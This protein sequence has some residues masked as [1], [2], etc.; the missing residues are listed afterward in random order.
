[1]FV[2]AVKLDEAGRQILERAGRRELA[3]DKRAAPALSGDFATDDEF[4]ARVLEDRF[5]DAAS[6]PVRTRS[7]DARPPSSS[8]TASTRMDLPAPVSPVKTFSPGS[9]STSTASMTARRL[10]LRNRSMREMGELQS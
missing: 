8:P 1:M 7:A 2:L 10:M 5:D 3:V 9:N 6:S 4:L